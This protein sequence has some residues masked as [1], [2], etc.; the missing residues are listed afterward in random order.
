[1]DITYILTEYI[2]ISFL[3]HYWLYSLNMGARAKQ[4]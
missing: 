4:V 2:D 1:M 3:L